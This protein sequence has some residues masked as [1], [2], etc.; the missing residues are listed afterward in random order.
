[1]MRQKHSIPVSQGLA[2]QEALA[3]SPDRCALRE[4]QPLS[5]PVAPVGSPATQLIGS[6]VQT[7]VHGGNTSHCHSQ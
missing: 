4:H 5:L 1:M 3:Q 2:G 6:K 7:D